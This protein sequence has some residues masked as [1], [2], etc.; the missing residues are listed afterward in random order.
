M[1]DIEI[2]DD[3]KSLDDAKQYMSKYGIVKDMIDLPE[4]T[5]KETE[6][7]PNQLWHQDGLQIEI[8]I[9]VNFQ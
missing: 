8:R 9:K 6:D 5:S 4:I 7:I 1:R 2:I 3:I